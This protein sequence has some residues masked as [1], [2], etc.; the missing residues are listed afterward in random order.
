MRYQVPQF[1]DVEDKIVGPF[2]IKQFLYL[3]GGGALVFISFFLFRLVYAIT[4]SIPIAVVAFSLAFVKIGGMS[5]PRYLTSLI[6]FAFK[7]Q[8]YHWK[9]KNKH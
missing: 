3:A 9:K 8:E 1:I 7:P 6:G 4:V 5:L 2:T